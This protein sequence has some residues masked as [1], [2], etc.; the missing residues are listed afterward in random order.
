AVKRLFKIFVLITLAS[1]QVTAQRQSDYTQYMFN[2]LLINP[3]Y[4]GI[5][6]ALNVTGLYRRQWVGFSGAPV[7]LNFSAHA[8]LKN[9]HYNT[10]VL[11]EN[12]RAGLFS[13]TKAAGAFAYRLP[14]FKGK[15]SMGIQ[16]GIAAQT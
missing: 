9:R 7:T 8:A 2:G 16:A 12:D 6:E 13:R 1:L 3:A 4:A 14:A 11:I 10:G 5:H 15:L